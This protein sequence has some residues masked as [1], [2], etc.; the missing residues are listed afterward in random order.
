MGGDRQA[1]G[2][3]VQ[4]R[5]QGEAVWDL[6]AQEGGD[7]LSRGAVQQLWRWEGAGRE[8][9]RYGETSLTVAKGLQGRN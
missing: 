3:G 6:G 4:G 7:D 9:G 8:Q 1:F 5:P 2:A